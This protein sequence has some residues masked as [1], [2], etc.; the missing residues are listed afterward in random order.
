MNKEKFEF[1]LNHVA[2]QQVIPSRINFQLAEG[3][4][5]RLLT[6]AYS[7]VNWKGGEV[8][9]AELEFETPNGP[10]QLTMMRCT[11]LTRTRI[12]RVGEA[13]IPSD[14]QEPDVDDVVM[15]AEIDFRLEYAVVDCTPAELDE[16]ALNEFLGKNAPFQMWPYYRELVQNLAVRANLPPPHIPPFRVPKSHQSNNK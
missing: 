13:G 5:V 10:T 15:D 9:L 14:D 7:R 1:V 4:D 3:F 12:V 11:V 2:L 8:S 16:Q 6:Q